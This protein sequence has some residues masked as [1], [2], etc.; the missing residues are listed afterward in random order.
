MLDFHLI[1]S[2]FCL[3]RAPHQWTSALPALRFPQARQI[4]NCSSDYYIKPFND[5]MY[6]RSARGLEYCQLR[7]VHNMQQ[8]T[9]TLAQV[10][11]DFF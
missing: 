6:Y 1:R 10:F 11:R 5:C 9:R 8:N 3:P 7:L 4:R 2:C